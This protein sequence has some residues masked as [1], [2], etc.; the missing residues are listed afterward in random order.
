MPPIFASKVSDLTCHDVGPPPP[1]C[2]VAALAAAVLLSA[3]PRPL[4]PLAVVS[5]RTYRPG[6]GGGGGLHTRQGVGLIL[7]RT[8]RIGKL[9]GQP[10][11]F[12]QFC[13]SFSELGVRVRA[14]GVPLGCLARGAVMRLSCRAGSGAER[15]GAWWRLY[16]P[17]RRNHHKD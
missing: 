2:H 8:V 9:I 4:G 1:C 15:G 3:L 11:F 16:K 14:V 13:F 5:Y 6:E 12:S 7:G 10:H 17:T